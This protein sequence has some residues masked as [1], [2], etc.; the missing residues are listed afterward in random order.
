[1]VSAVGIPRL[2]AGEDVKKHGFGS[3][4]AVDA[5]REGLR[6]INDKP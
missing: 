2:Q 6:A 3:E 5:Y 1:M 4:Q